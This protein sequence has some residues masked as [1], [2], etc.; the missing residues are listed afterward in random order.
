MPFILVKQT[1]KDYAK[2]K[3]L[4]DKHG[5]TRKKS[6]SKGGR[7]YRNSQNPNEIVVIMEW[8]AI[9]NARKFTESADLREIMEKAGVI[10]KP[11]VYFLEQ[12]ETFKE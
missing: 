11:E 10:G 7:L 1:I 2:W 3:P 12:I 8:D 6:G 5:S 9:D 4:F